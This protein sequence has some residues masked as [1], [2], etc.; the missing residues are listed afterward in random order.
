MTYGKPNK[1]TNIITDIKT[2]KDE[3]IVCFNFRSLSD[4]GQATKN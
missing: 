1:Y 4:F 2:P 3:K